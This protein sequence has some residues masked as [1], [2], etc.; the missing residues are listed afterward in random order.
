M[1]ASVVSPVLILQYPPSHHHLAEM[2]RRGQGDEPDLFSAAYNFKQAARQD[3]PPSLY[4]LV[5]FNERTLIFYIFYL[6]FTRAVLFLEIQ[7]F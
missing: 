7:D 1:N 5:G 3:Y 2:M 6:I 4:E